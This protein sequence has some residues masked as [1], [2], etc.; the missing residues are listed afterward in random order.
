[1]NCAAAKKACE[2]ILEKMDE[3]AS[4][5]PDGS[6]AEKCNACYILG[7]DLSARHL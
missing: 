2:M 6:W 4:Q 5:I 1:M 3:V 7:I